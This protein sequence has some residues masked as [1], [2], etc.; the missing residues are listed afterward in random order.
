MSLVNYKFPSTRRLIEI[1]PE[2]I[3]N[4]DRARPTAEL[5][6]E[7]NDNDAW[8]LE[9][10]QRDNYR[11]FQQLRGLNGQPS[12]VKMVGRK[13]F[14]QEPGVFG[15]FMYI[16]ERQ[17]TMR[18]RFADNREGGRVEI[19]DLVRERQDYLLAREGDL[20]EWLGWAIL[21]SGTF[22]LLG[23]TGAQF[24]ATF[25]IQTATFS[26]WSDHANA[27][28][29]ADLLGIKSLTRGKSVSFGANAVAR[30]N[31]T[32]SMHLLLNTNPDDLG[33]K[34]IGFGGLRV[35]AAATLADIN[36][37][38]RAAGIPEIREYD[39]G[40]NAES[41]GA[42]TE[43]LPDGDVSIVGQ[44]T[45]GAKLGA[46]RNVTNV[47]NPNAAAGAYTKVIDTLERTVPRKI[48]VHRG[49]NGGNVLYYPSAILKARVLPV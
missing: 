24:V 37:V 42:F 30:M 21:L 10:Y 19:G 22:A 32:T 2:L 33:G 25:P 49:H 47:N 17:M 43:W 46:Y 15:E 31:S 39:E 28:P 40:Y 29:Y 23:P 20:K 36:A 45:N 38:F 14:S 4:R 12:Y 48:S 7:E 9:W 35:G 13:F 16:D 27:T 6:P 41:N 26:D 8:R 1:E 11:G 44:R 5:F 3:R 34:F 18:A